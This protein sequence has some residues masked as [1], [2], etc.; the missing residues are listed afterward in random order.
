MADYRFTDLASKTIEWSSKTGL[1]LKAA[2]KLRIEE[3]DYFGNGEW[4]SKGKATVWVETFIDG[5]SQG[6]FWEIRTVKNNP[7]ILGALGDIGLRKESYDLIKGAIEEVQKHEIFKNQIA[8]EKAAD[9]ADKNY[10]AS[11]KGICKHCD[12]YCYGDCQA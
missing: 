12:S 10:H 4:S 7:E 1:A 2:I 6:N 3:Q 11:R 5:K 8:A 9:E